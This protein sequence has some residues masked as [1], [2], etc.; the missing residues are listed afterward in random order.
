MFLKR[1]AIFRSENPR[2]TVHAIYE[3]ETADSRRDLVNKVSRLL[4]VH[5]NANIVRA[6]ID[7]ITVGNT[8][9]DSQLAVCPADRSSYEILDSQVQRP[10]HQ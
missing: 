1:D 5:A 3:S 6:V 4:S 10:I 2:A 9:V 8:A 7:N